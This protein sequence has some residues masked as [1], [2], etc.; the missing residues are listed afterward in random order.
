MPDRK[1][2]F[3][4]MILR[5]DRY[6]EPAAVSVELPAGYTFS[7]YQPG[8]EADWARMEHA[9]G[10]FPSPEEASAYF[11]NTYLAEPE[12]LQKR[13]VF[14]MDASGEAVGSCIAWKDPRGESEVSSLHWL[15]VSPA[16]R[17]QGL[18]RA[19]CRRVM[20]I[21]AAHNE[22]PVY[23]HTQPWSWKAVLLYC[24]LGFCLE[25]TDSFA[26]Y[27]NQ[28]REAMEVLKQILNEDQYQRLLETS[29][30]TL[31]AEEI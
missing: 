12:V 16:H 23:I 26:A 11:A 29:R 21:F 18:G 30:E 9:I 14:I 6:E 17:G 1:I 20:D 27:E 19:L 24:S 28:Y 5:C 2:P 8:L 4:N 22:L 13:A 31:P 10:D 25:K 3:F 15:V 7:A